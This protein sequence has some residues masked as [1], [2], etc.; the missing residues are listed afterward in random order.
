MDIE[1]DRYGYRQ[2]QI[3]IDIELGIDIDRFRYTCRSTTAGDTGG[4][5][6]RV[7]GGDGA[8]NR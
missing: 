8:T 3:D 6:R 4:G 5:R 2:I 1:F 7:R